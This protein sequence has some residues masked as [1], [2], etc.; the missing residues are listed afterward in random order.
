MTSLLLAG[1]LD[2]AGNLGNELNKLLMT[3]VMGLGVT[4]ATI[5]TWRTTKSVIAAFVATLGGVALW[6]VVTHAAAFRDSIGEDIAPGG[7]TAASHV[8]VRVD[9]PRDAA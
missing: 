9:P 1:A 4:L 2:D 5:A 7:G 6:Y 8:V 3:V